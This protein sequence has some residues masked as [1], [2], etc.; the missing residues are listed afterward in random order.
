MFRFGDGRG[1]IIDL[2]G[3]EQGSKLIQIW[4]LDDEGET[5]SAWRW[6]GVENLYV[7]V[8]NLAKCRF[9]SLHIALRKFLP[10]YIQLLAQY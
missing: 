6:S 3:P 7:M 1:P 10:I 9:H 2:I 5:N 4:G 8:G